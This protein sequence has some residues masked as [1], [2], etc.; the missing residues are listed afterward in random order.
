LSIKFFFEKDFYRAE[1]VAYMVAEIENESKI[2][3]KRV[4][5]NFM[6]EVRVEGG[7]FRR[8]FVGNLGCVG[9][10]G[11]AANTS[12]VGEDAV[13][14]ELKLVRAIGVHLVREIFA[15]KMNGL[16]SGMGLLG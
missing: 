15:L 2:W 8:E 13:R 14:L 4:F 7:K 9:V 11:V 10:V 1:E 5:G 6:Q 12:L 16:T 3:V